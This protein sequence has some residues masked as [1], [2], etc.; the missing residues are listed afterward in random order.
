VPLVIDLAAG[1][2]EVPKEGRLAGSLD[3]ELALARLADMLGLD[4]Q[5]LE[6]PLLADLRLGGTVAVPTIDGTVRID[7]ALYENGTTGTVLRDVNLLVTA[8]RRTIAIERFSASDGGKGRLSGEGTVQLDPAA[9]YPVD[10]RL[11]V[12]RARIVARDEIDATASGALTLDGS[13]GAPKLGGTITVNHAEISIPERLGPRIAVIPV[14]EIGGGIDPGSPELIDS[15]SQL[16][17]GL[18]L[19]VALPGRVFVRGRGLDSE[20]QG[21]LHAE[22]TA[23]HPRVTGS[24]KVMRGTF[25]LLGR[26][27]NL[28]TGNIQFAGQTPPNPAIDIQAVT[29]ANDITAVVRVE[30]EATAPEFSLGSEPSMPEDEIL[31]RILFNRPA[32]RLGPADALQVAEAV[33]TLRGGGYGVLG[34]VRQALGLDTL[35]VSGQT[36]GDTQVRAGRHLNDRVFVTV[37]KG[38]APDSEDVSVEVEILPSLSLDADTNARMQSGIGLNWRFDY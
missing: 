22:G 35:D 34:R 12:K 33:N 4:D 26:V 27:F 24:L 7:S 16:D 6:G 15:E 37:G 2:I 25:E 3:A 38:T 8:N 10:L 31:A 20:W 28:R 18:D 14:E 5:R 32:S 36:M 19:T 11:E 29:N 1:V 13:V 21:R 9:D 17:L 30:G 23:A